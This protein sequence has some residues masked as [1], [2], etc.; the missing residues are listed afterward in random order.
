MPEGFANEKIDTLLRLDLLVE[1][2]GDQRTRRW[3]VRLPLPGRAQIA[4]DQRIA[5]GGLERHA[6]RRLVDREGAF[7][8]P[9]HG[10]LF[11]AAVKRH[12]LQNLGARDEKFAIEGA[13]GVRMAE[14]DLRRESAGDYVAASFQL[15]NVAAIAQ[16]DAILQVLDNSLLHPT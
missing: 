6:G 12:H 10:E 3:T 9:Y 7:G 4:G 2:P 13:D 14:R 15:H 1:H 5:A 11:A 8:F 16:D